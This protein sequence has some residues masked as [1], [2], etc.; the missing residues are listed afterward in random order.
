MM[1]PRRPQCRN[2]LEAWVPRYLIHIGPFKTGTTYLQHA[3]TQMRPELAARGIVY[4]EVWGGPHGHHALADSLVTGDGASLREAFGRLNHSGAEVV[5][6]SSEEFAK[7]GEASVHRLHAL[8]GSGAVTVVF[9]C[10][11][12]SE[13]IPSLWREAIKH[14]SLTTFP[15][16][17]LSCLSDPIAAEELN[18]GHVLTRY[19]SVFGER[20]LKLVS[21]NGVLEAGMDLLTHFSQHFLGWA[22]PPASGLG[23]VNE[24]LDMVDSEI[25]RALNALEWTRARE[26]RKRLHKPFLEAKDELPVRFLV[27]RSMQFLVNSIRL[28]DAA[29]ILARMHTELADRYKAALVPPFP[30]GSLFKPRCTDVSYI[31]QDYLFAEEVL[32]TLRAMQTT[33]LQRVQ[34]A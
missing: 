14:G 26:D 9:Y 34:K 2:E 31:R 30:V 33:L 1:S 32:D 6:L 12:W 28:D 27:E 5:L 3:F 19:T 20:A 21:Y 17:A 23:R 15:E 29:P 8:I 16:F 10:R 25:I 24:S 4:P 13:L 11:R 18:F 22:N 7:L